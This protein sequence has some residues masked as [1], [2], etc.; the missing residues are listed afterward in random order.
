MKYEEK[1]FMTVHSSVCVIRFAAL[2]FCRQYMNMKTNEIYKIAKDA[3]WKYTYLKFEY[4]LH[5]AI[6]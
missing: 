6:K 3:F 5:A 1:C 2:D 4:P